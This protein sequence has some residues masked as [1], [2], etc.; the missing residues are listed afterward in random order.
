[1]DTTIRNLDETAY[2]QL[3]A[4]AALSGRS[5]GE[6]VNEAIRAYLARPQPPLRQQS[7]ADLVPEDYGE[8]AEQLSEEI[9]AVAYG[10]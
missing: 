8:G 3:K 2:R 1:M 5:I 7:L 10:A 6:L 9:D 4:R